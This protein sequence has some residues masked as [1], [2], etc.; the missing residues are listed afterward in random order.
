MDIVKQ[1]LLATGALALSMGAMHGVSANSTYQV[2]SGDTLSQISRVTHVS[3][4]DLQSINHISNINFIYPGQTLQLD[5]QSA[6]P[7]APAQQQQT[8]GDTTYTVKAGDTASRI[9]SQFGLTLAQLQSLNKIANINLIFV[10]Q[11]LIVKR[12]SNV[13]VPTVTNTA[14]PQS[15]PQQQQATS[16]AVYRVVSGD[17]MSAIA[18]KHNMSLSALLNMNGMNASQ[19]IYVGQS[20]KVAGSAPVATPVNNNNNNQAAPQ[21]Q[22]T[23]QGAVYRV[24][25]G[26]TMSAIAA[27]HNMSLSALL[28]MNGMNASQIIYVGQSIKVTGAAP[29]AAPVNNTQAAPQQQQPAANTTTSTYTIKSGDTLYGISRSHGMSLQELLSL[30]NISASSLILPGQVLKI[31][32]NTNTSTQPVAPSPVQPQSQQASVSGATYTIKSGDTLY[33][34][35]MKTGMSLQSL[36]SMNNLSASSLIFPGQVLKVAGNNQSVTTPT[37]PTTGS[38][39]SQMVNLSNNT[40]SSTPVGDISTA[41]LSAQQAAWLRQAAVDAKNA[42]LGSGVLPSVTVAQAIIESNWG[43]SGLSIAPYNN[44]FG[45]KAGGYWGG[46]QV[47][48]PTGEYLNGRYVTVNAA[49]RAYDSQEA[50]FRDHTNFLLQNSRYAAN[51][52]INAPSYQAM[53]TGLQRAGYATDPSYAAT[54]ISV[55]QRYNLNALD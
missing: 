5:R 23:T 37:A 55:V 21:Q 46:R 11:R 28:N 40:V 16:G 38:Q 51:G 2:K 24:V 8:S 35:A 22:Q 29:V 44:L 14:K 1:S 36:L 43:R 20:I 41:G 48:M 31:S 54:L 12:G 39:P 9:A 47:M 6:A 27:K 45:I 13:A 4:S 49:F 15:A 18:A 19:I 10:G 30:N 3:M 50:S 34:I 17:T 33:G 25:S 7:K 32:G 52:V 42:T 53:A 26:D